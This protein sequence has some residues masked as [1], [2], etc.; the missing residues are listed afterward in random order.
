[1]SGFF[2]LEGIDGAGTTTQA[3]RLHAHLLA[4]SGAALLTAE[5]ST[6]PIG[7]L[8]RQALARRIVLPP[9]AGAGPLDT[10]AM[11]L[12]F[13]AD[14][15]DHLA[16]EIAPALE[17]GIPVVSDRYYHSSYAYQGSE[18]ELEFVRS[19]N[20][21]ARV[22]DLTILLDLP[23]EVAMER[24]RLRLAA[25]GKSADLYETIAIQ[26]RVAEAYRRL[27]ALL[28]KERIIVI[29][30]TQAVDRVQQEILDLVESELP[31]QR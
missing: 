17:A 11:A 22:P 20:A 23:P 1:M 21:R 4:K 18:T 14:R 8:I 24:V 10:D 12:L 6:G 2:V 26:Q 9:K 19:L 5:P 31:S 16:A 3:A 25:T 28:S 7:A 13:A 15:M 27:P 30:A 29:D